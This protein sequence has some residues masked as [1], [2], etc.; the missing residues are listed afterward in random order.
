MKEELQEAPVPLGQKETEQTKSIELP[1]FGNVHISFR[2][3]R[4]L[5]TFLTN[6]TLMS[7]CF[8]E[9]SDCSEDGLQL[10]RND[11]LSHV[12]HYILQRRCIFVNGVG[13]VV[14]VVVVVEAGA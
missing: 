14:V 6:F 7:T 9:V 11:G 10:S 5:A 1:R 4:E 13:A 2:S 8:S 12:P 3:R